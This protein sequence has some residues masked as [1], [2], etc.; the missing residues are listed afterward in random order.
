[1]ARTD[2]S[3]LFGCDEIVAQWVAARIDHAARGFG[4]CTAL[5]VMSGHRLICGCVYHDWHP[6]FG[7]I[8]LSIAASSP[9][10]ARRPIIAGLLAYPF[11]QIGA[12]LV[13]SAI[14]ADNR[15][16]LRVCEHV[17]FKREAILT[18]RF[19]RGRHATVWFMKRHTYRKLYE[20]RDHGK[21]HAEPPACA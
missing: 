21:V 1:M 16:S 4:P 10:W 20:D 2:P 5:G 12:R 15:R 6:D 9:M 19:G 13:W 14:P 17:G 7:T 11:A 8:Q 3:L 18:E